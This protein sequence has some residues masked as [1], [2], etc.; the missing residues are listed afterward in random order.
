MAYFKRGYWRGT[1]N[2]IARK[3]INKEDALGYEGI[4]V[5][6]P[7]PVVAP[8]VVESIEPEIVEEDIE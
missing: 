7:A 2:G 8:A 5:P 1:R 4:V 3:F 6:A